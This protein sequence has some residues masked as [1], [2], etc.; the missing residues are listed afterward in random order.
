MS[1]KSIPSE[2][3]RLK[4]GSSKNPKPPSKDGY[5]KSGKPKPGGPDIR[6][7]ISV[8]Q[9]PGQHHRASPR[10][11]RARTSGSFKLPGK[12]GLFFIWDRRALF[13]EKRWRA[14]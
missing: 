5:G 12:P 3:W 7:I 1:V 8:F 9:K 2:I 6:D 14:A 13:L 11:L 4:T 10:V